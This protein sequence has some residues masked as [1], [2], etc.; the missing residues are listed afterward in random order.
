MGERVAQAPYVYFLSHALAVEEP[1]KPIAPARP[2]SLVVEVGNLPIRL[3]CPNPHFARLIEE[4]Y[5]GFLSSSTEVIGEFEIELTPPAVRFRN[6]DVRVTW[7]SD[8][9]LIERTDFQAR[10][11]PDTRRGQ[12]LQ[13]DSIYALDSVLRI[14]DTL[15]LARMGGFLL[16]ASSWIRNGRAFLF[17]GPSGAS[18]TTVAR[19]APPD[20][21]LLSDGLSCVIRRGDFY[22]SAGTPF[23][24]GLGRPGEN[25]AA[26]I[27]SL[28][29]L[30]QG[31]RNKI[32]AIESATAVRGLLANVV[33]FASDPELVK[34]VFEASCEFVSRVPVRRL[35]FVPD[36]S[37]WGLIE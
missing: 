26:P 12:I 11:N 23:Y 1:V 22:N 6:E 18:K 8:Q 16:H 15:I 32:E 4:R 37:V 34:L 2:P 5:S 13:S 9:W 14:V 31:V 36:A 25:R 27:E 19:L 30:S 10:W 28:Y 17:A 3:R 24:C 29:L 21:S 7:D 20:A 33:F 35:T